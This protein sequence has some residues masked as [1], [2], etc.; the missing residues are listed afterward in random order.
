MPTFKSLVTFKSCGIVYV[1][2]SNFGI[3]TIASLWHPMPFSSYAIR[4]DGNGCML[5]FSDPSYPFNCR[6]SFYET[7]N[8]EKI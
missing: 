2:T 8:L 7:I 3:G 5:T 4:V 6:L 1:R